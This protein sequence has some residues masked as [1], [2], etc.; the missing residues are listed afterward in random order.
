MSQLT[1]TE[2]VAKLDTP[3]S[4]LAGRDPD[5]LVTTISVSLVVNPTKAHFEDDRRGR[6]RH[7]LH[8]VKIGVVPVRIRLQDDVPWPWCIDAAVQRLFYGKRHASVILIGKRKIHGLE[9]AGAV[10]SIDGLC[11]PLSDVFCRVHHALLYRPLKIGQL[12]PEVLIRHAPPQRAVTVVREVGQPP[13]VWA[14]WCDTP[15]R[16]PGA[17][18]GSAFPVGR[19]SVWD[20]RSPRRS[21]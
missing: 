13:D 5:G 16:S 10:S 9:I 6:S 17:S 21:L 15:P 12:L 1:Q 11:V 3:V 4:L 2:I 8:E 19:R 7:F 20:R 18:A 14:A